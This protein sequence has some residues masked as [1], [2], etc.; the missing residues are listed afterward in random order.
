MFFLSLV[1]VANCGGNLK[2][3]QL[4]IEVR[5]EAILMR[6]IDEYAQIVSVP[7]A[8]LIS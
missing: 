4:N 5:K 3:L 8:L 2:D 7:C 6:E 1:K